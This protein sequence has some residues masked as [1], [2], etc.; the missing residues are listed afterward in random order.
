MST[1]TDIFYPEVLAKTTKSIQNSVDTKNSFEDRIED[2][3]DRKDK[4]ILPCLPAVWKINQ[5]IK[6]TSHRAV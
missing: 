4:H 3:E 6:L 2:M 5:S 1:L